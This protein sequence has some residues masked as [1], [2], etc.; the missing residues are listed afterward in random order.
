MFYPPQAWRV[1][2]TTPISLPSLRRYP[3]TE[4]ALEAS[5]FV[6]YDTQ[7]LASLSRK[8]SRS[9]LRIPQLKPMPL[10]GG[11]GPP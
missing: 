4:T 11:W 3:K 7:K 1:T 6:V 9:A 8:F 2:S 10:P 5:A